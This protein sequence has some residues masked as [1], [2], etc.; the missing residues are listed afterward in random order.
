MKST[1]DWLFEVLAT[2][3]CRAEDNP[4]SS[5]LRAQGMHLQWTEQEAGR[6]V[7]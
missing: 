3:P 1:V 4:R 7:P 5:S 2:T 6:L